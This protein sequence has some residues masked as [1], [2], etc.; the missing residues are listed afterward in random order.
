MLIALAIILALGAAALGP[1]SLPRP[2]QPV[3]PS[4]PQPWLVGL[5]AF[6]LSLPWFVLAIL[7]YIVPP[8]LPA[9]VPLLIGL[10]WVLAAF[11][12][13]RRWSAGPA[14]Q[15]AHRLAL[16]FGPL[17]ASMGARF[18]INGPTLSPV[19]LMGKVVLNVMAVLLLAY[20][21]WKL[22]RRQATQ[23]APGPEPGRS[24]VPRAG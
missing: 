13:I 19:D 5:V 12:L 8:S 16:I 14:W 21:A 11:F 1:W 3:V 22:H 17:V 23:G 18:V 9:V 10:A 15:D 4:A 20:L 24:G 6:V 2:A 7:P